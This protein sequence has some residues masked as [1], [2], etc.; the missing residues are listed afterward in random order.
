MPPGWSD[1]R[2]AV[3]KPDGWDARVPRLPPERERHAG[4]VRADAAELPHGRL[5]AEGRRLDPAWPRRAGS[6]LPLARALAPHALPVE[7]EDVRAPGAQ[8]SPVP[9]ARHQGAFAE[10]PLPRPR[11]FDEVDISTSR[12]RSAAGTAL[13]RAD[14]RGRARVPQ[15]LESLLAV[16]EG[17]AQVVEALRSAGELGEHGAR[18]YIRQRLPARRASAL[19]DRG[20]SLPVSVRAC[21]W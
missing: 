20:K 16:D 21:R 4:R 1:W 9:A 15:R 14:E 6:R 12:G 13:V 18:V 5:H 7:P 10:E 3:R 19:P 2:A 11:S 17:V 8:L